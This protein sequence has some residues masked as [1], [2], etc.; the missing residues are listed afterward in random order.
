MTLF[1]FWRQEWGGRKHRTPPEDAVV[2]LLG[3]AAFLVMLL[4][5]VLVTVLQGRDYHAEL[6]ASRAGHGVEG[7]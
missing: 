5:Y 2:A 3:A 6:A 1:K 4:F 7:Y